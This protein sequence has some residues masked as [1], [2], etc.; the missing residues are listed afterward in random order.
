MI[1]IRQVNSKARKQHT[2]D[3]CIG[4]I[5]KS[6]VYSRG[7]HV[8]DGDIYTWK[9]HLGCSELARLI[10]DRFAGDYGLTADDFNEGVRELFHQIR[11]DYD[12]TWEDM[13]IAVKAHYLEKK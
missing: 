13:L 12:A 6:E 9:S 10:Y 5:E 8:H 2:C 4:K 1:N 7:T 11:D 3:Y